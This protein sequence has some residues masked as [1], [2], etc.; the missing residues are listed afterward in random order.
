M[1]INAL[2]GLIVSS[3]DTGIFLWR[4]KIFGENT[5]QL[6]SVNFRLIRNG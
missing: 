4:Y 3:D 5:F 6:E 2:W 1:F